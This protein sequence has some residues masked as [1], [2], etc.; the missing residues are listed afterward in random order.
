[1]NKLLLSFIATA[2]F[3][4]FQFTV[5]PVAFAHP[6]GLDAKGCHHDTATGEYH[7]H[8]GANAGKSF[9]SEESMEKGSRGTQM[10]SESSSKKE[11]SADKDDKPSKSKKSAKQK[12][13]DN[14]DK[15]SKKSD[16][17][18]QAKSGEAASDKKPKGPSAA[19]I[20]K[21]CKSKEAGDVVTIKGKEVTC[22]E[23]KAMKKK[24]TKQ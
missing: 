15:S 10:R 23:K 6:G 22:P 3:A 13:K 11:S 17:K 16:T 21:A 12:E 20:T 7:C 5:S 9:A 14:G 2:A 18:K 1:M 4:V 19:A 8:Q 24:S